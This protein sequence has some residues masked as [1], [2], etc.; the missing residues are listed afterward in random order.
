MTTLQQ[1]AVLNEEIISCRKCLRLARYRERIACTKRRAYRDW[2]YWGRPVPGF[3]DPQAE[4][5]II[6]LAP[7]AHATHRTGAMFTGDR[8]GWRRARQAPRSG[9]HTSRLQA[10]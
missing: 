3:G 10:T 9:D 2:T 4:L 8:S 6:G 7:A 1:L 5:L